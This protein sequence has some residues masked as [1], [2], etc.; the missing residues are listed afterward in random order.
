[1]AVY[2][3]PGAIYGWPWPSTDG[4]GSPFKSSTDDGRARSEAGRRR[5]TT[6]HQGGSEGRFWQVVAQEQIPGRSLVVQVVQVSQDTVV[7]PRF[8]D[9]GEIVGTPENQTLRGT[10]TS[11]SLSVALSAG[12][13]LAGNC[14]GSRDQSTS[15]RSSRHPSWSLLLF[16]VEQVQPAIRGHVCR[17]PSRCR[18]RDSCTHRCY[19]APVTT[20]T[21]APTVFPTATVLISRLRQVPTG[22]TVRKP[23]EIPQIMDKVICHARCCAT[24]GVR[25]SDLHKAR[26]DSTVADLGQ[27]YLTF[28]LLCNDRCP[29]S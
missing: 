19:V 22:Q 16:V 12:S 14:G 17:C 2:G 23:V 15:R 3:W 20:R 11:E 18:V 10:Q 9:R 25:G 27:G 21:A 26:G 5:C 8:A 13:T 24:T 7:I 4:Q 29:W 6:K 1:M 28:P